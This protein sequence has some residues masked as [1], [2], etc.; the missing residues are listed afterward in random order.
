VKGTVLNLRF[1][2]I[3]EFCDL[4][5]HSKEAKEEIRNAFN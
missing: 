4:P 5:I 2:D 3:R 1:H